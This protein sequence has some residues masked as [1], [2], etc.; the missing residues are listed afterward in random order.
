MKEE[1]IYEYMENNKLNIENIV[2][3]YSNYIKRIIKSKSNLQQEDVEELISDVFVVL[4]NNQE[5]L[6]ISKNISPYIAGITKNLIKKKYKYI[7][8]NDNIEDFEE[9]L[10]ITNDI[11]IYKDEANDIL[12]NE[13]NKMKN[14]EQEIF[15]KYYFENKKIKEIANILNFSESKIKMK[16][17]RTKKKLKKILKER[18]M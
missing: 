3:N 5:K 13:L 8:L 9:K 4:W 7:N 14:D 2:K 16:L 17:H 12:M 1:K 6:D 11:E 18:G 10:A 15:V